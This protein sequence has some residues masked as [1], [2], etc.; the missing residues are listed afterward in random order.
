[1]ILMLQNELYLRAWL[2][3][4]PLVIMMIIDEENGHKTLHCESA[5]VQLMVTNNVVLLCGYMTWL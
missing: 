4:L 1:M 3:A 5:V 2:S